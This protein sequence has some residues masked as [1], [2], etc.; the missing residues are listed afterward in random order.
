MQERLGVAVRLLS[1]LEHEVKR[2]AKSDAGL[3]IVT[4]APIGGIAGILLVDDRGHAPEGLFDLRLCRNAVL[5]PVG[6]MLAGDPERRAVFHQSD[7]GH[8]RH[9]RTA[10]ALVDPAHHVAEDS[11]RIV[12]EFGL[13]V[14][15]G[16]LAIADRRRQDVVEAC[17]RTL[18]ELTLARGDVDLVV[19]QCVQGRRGR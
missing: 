6:D 3:V 5:Q 10:D 12:V 16:I 1:A 18:R 9:L 14:V 4:H 17:Q 8:V 7:I 15:G 19:M 13:D 11:L 2:R